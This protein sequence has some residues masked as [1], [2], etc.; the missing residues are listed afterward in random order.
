MSAPQKQTYRPLYD[1]RAILEMWPLIVGDGNVTELRALEATTTNDR[2]ARTR[3]GYFNSGEALATAVGEL[4]SAKGIYIVSNLVNPDLLARS[5]NRIK[6]AGKGDATQDSDIIARRWLPVDA[7]PVRPTNISSNDG[8]HEA[9]LQRARA[10]AAALQAR[11]WPEPILADS[12]NGAHGL[13]R[14]DVPVNDG[15]LV[16]RCLQALSHLFDDDAVKVDQKVFNAARIWRCYGTL[17]CKGDDI[18]ERPHRMSRILHVPKELQ[19]VSI[20]LLQALAKDAPDPDPIDRLETHSAPGESFDIGAFIQRHR[21]DVDGPHAWNGQQGPGRRWVFRISPMCEHHGDGPYIIQHAS[22]A[23]SAGCHHNSCSWNWRD[24]RAKIEPVHMR[25]EPQK[26]KITAGRTSASSP[27]PW[28][29]IDSL[30]KGTLP[31]F[32]LRALP[33]ALRNWVAAESHATQTPI[34]LPGLLSLAACSSGIARYVEIEPR[35]GFREPANLYV[36]VLLEPGNRKSAVF[37]DAIRPLSE[38]E[39][40]LIESQRPHFARESSDRRQTKRR[41]ERLEKI[42][43]EK[44]DTDAR[45]EARELAAKLAEWPEPVLPQLIV[46]NVTD[47]KLG[48][49][50]AQHGGRIASMSPEGGVFDLMAGLYSKSGTPSFDVYLKAHAGDDVRVDRVS[51]E[52]VYVKRPALTCAYAMQPQVIQGLA[53]KPAFRGR[54]LLARFLYSA[55]R[56]W[57]GRREIGADPVPKDVANEYSRTVRSLAE[58]PPKGTLRLQPDAELLFRDWE[59]EI[60]STL[61]DGGDLEMIRDW[62]SKLAGATLRLAATMHFVRHSSPDA[63][64]IGVDRETMC[65]AISIA[66]YL[67]PHAE[68]V[69]SMMLVHEVTAIDDARYVLKWI[70]RRERREFTKREAYQDGKRRFRKT[71]DMDPALHELTRRGYIRKKPR[72]SGG[73]GRP[74]SPCYETNPVVFESGSAEHRSQNPQKSGFGDSGGASGDSDGEKRVRIAI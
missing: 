8:E 48:M 3:F 43:A 25:R 64:A 20:D 2:Y 58:N 49:L 12:G 23:I 28:P 6:P 37:N 70:I 18:P 72:D 29:A 5:F 36:A 10:I 52:G 22:G 11:G 67:I 13:Y 66:R 44:G 24:L 41:L 15:G 39:A 63:L 14:V 56:S 21:L 59:G 68:N 7:D 55:P 4:R 69:L 26:G 19:V 33:D 42:A 50:L 46:D 35:P 51:R 47:E 61:A 60:E 31:E 40:Q 1:R 16:Q 53:D 32:P 65:G 34:D 54:G 71:D 17:A 38:L 74:P 57:I 45:D 27:K 62:G 73:P 9:A 30:E